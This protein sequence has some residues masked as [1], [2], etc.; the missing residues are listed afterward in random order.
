MS[1]SLKLKKKRRPFIK[2]L[3]FLGGPIVLL[4]RPCSGRLGLSYYFNQYLQI[5]FITVL[6]ILIK[7]VPPSTYLTMK[8]YKGLGE[9]SKKA[10]L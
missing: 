3:I 8:T 1:V 5:V 9:G 7:V 6:Q 10:T 4:F 2:V